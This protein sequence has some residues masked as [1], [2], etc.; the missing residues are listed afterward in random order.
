M[1]G[2]LRI[3]NLIPAGENESLTLHFIPVTLF[4]SMKVS[5]DRHIDSFR[6]DIEVEIISILILVN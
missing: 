5:M 2:W 4:P 3:T 1:N 6:N